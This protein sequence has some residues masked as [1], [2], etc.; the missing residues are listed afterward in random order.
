MPI[1]GEGIG[2]V[3]EKIRSSVADMDVRLELILKV[4]AFGTIAEKV[5][6]RTACETQKA[7]STF[8]T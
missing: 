7:S 2:I 3:A 1:I 5:I 6:R 8:P 4:L